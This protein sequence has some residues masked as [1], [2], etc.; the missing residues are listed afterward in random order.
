MRRGP[1][2]PALALVAATFVLVAGCWTIPS[3]LPE[4][5]IAAAQR[6]FGAVYGGDTAAVNALVGDDIVISYPVFESLFGTSALRGRQAAREFAAHFARRWGESSFRIERSVAD[7]AQV[8]L[9]WSFRARSLAPPD[10]GQ[11]S[12]WGGITYIRFDEAGRIVA[13]IGEESTPGPMGR[14]AASAGS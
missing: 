3:D 6:Y 10:S 7:S 1:S 9:V 14:L 4:R 2:A 5:H 8:A 11:M 12:A 13:E